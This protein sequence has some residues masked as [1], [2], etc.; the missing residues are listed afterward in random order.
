[1]K[2]YTGERGHPL[3]LTFHQV[4]LSQKCFRWSSCF[5][6]WPKFPSWVTYWNMTEIGILGGSPSTASMLSSDSLVSTAIWVSH[7]RI[8]W[9]SLSLWG[10]GQVSQESH[11][12]GPPTHLSGLQPTPWQWPHLTH[13]HA[14]R[15]PWWY[16]TGLRVLGML[17]AR[18]GWW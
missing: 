5:C 15:V 3:V 9:A 1:M 16:H 8:T 6:S 2:K 18:R 11:Q 13:P 10:D 14:C 4:H 17:R 12:L 7:Q